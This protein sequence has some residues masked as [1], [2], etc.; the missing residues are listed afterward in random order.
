MIEGITD[1]YKGKAPDLGAYEFGGPRWI[2]GADWRDPE[3][4]AAPAKN[5]A[6]A[7]REPIT[8]KTMITNGLVLWFDATDKGSLELGGDGTVLAWHDKS[9]HKRVALPVLPN[10][11]VKWVDGGMNGQAV[12]RGNGTGS[13][14]VAD[15]KREPGSVTVFVVSQA[16]EASG[17]HWQRIIASF[18]GAG[19]EWVWPN[20]MIGVPGGEKPST[21]PAQVFTIQKWNGAALGTITVLGTSDGQ[22]QALGG[23]VGEVL[24]FDRT[25][26]F[27][28]MEAVQKYLAAKW[29][30]TD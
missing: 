5:L 23:D 7:P 20:W 27:D 13:L 28:E 4:P 8:P 10:G 17:P 6:Y 22:G 11:A 24:V 9:P 12:V 15:L 1:G 2:A 18:T 25:L 21:W 29:R 30:T 26:R 19:K 3:A 16:L 14:R